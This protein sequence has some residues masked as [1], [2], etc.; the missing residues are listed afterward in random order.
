LCWRCSFSTIWYVV[1]DSIGPFLGTRSTYSS[2]YLSTYSSTMVHRVPFFFLVATIV[3]RWYMEV[4]WY[5]QYHLYVRQYHYVNT[6][7]LYVPWYGTTGTR[8]RTRQ[9]HST[10]I[11]VARQLVVIVDYYDATLQYTGR[12]RGYCNPPPDR[13][14]P[15]GDTETHPRLLPVRASEELRGARFLDWC[16]PRVCRPLQHGPSLQ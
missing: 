16:F 11:M 15:R 4:P 7:C 13:G 14:A 5:G 8:V 1:L 12:G 6:I 9:Y 3:L 2:T 10:I